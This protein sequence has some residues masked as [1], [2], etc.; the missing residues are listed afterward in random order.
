MTSAVGVDDELGLA[1]ISGGREQ[2]WIVWAI[3]LCRG[4]QLAGLRHTAA[5]TTSKILLARGIWQ[6]FCETGPKI[7]FLV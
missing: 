6:N 4:D 2:T 7:N 1:R 3:L 5:R